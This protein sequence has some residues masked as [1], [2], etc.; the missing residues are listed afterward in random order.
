MRT[1]TLPLWL[2]LASAATAQVEVYER[3][4][5]S[6]GDG[7]GSAVATIDDLDGDGVRDLL[8]GA[9]RADLGALNGGTVHIY[10]GASGAK[11]GE[12]YGTFGS[13]LFGTSVA[14]VPDLD[15]DGTADWIAG[16]PF[17]TVVSA[18]VGRA[19]VRSG[20]DGSTLLGF[21]GT[22][23][24]GLLGLAVACPGDLTGDGVPEVIVSAPYEDANGTDSGHVYV[25]SGVDGALLRSHTGDN[26]GDLFGQVLLDLGDVSGDGVGDYAIA[27]E[28][29]ANSLGQLRAFGGANGAV[30]Y[31]NLGSSATDGFASAAARVDD[32]DGDGAAD[33]LVGAPTDATN[34]FEAGAVFVLSGTSGAQI[35][36]IHGGLSDELG[37]SVGDAGDWDGDGTG[38]LAVAARGPSPFGEV[39]VYSGVDSSLLVLITG[40]EDHQDFGAGLVGT[41]DIDGDGHCELAITDPLSDSGGNDAGSLLVYSHHSLVGT[42]YCLADGLGGLCPCANFSFDGGG[43]ANSSGSGALL[44]ASGS[45]SVSVDDLALTVTAA[46]P[47]QAALLF[48]GTLQENGGLG[49]S[50]GDGLLCAG[51]A[52]QRLHVEIPGAGGGATWGPGLAT[53]A[54]WAAGQTRYLQVWY[55]DTSGGPCSGGYNLSQGLELELLP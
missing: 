41:F 6:P 8:V 51:G 52:I 16:A 13:G 7:L 5:L 14:A 9:P 44:S 39:R 12:P 50:L 28:R 42:P 24:F 20:A 11:L 21:T 54:G 33:I 48:F 18:K 23:A 46:I 47:G 36:A 3:D 15:G 19:E 27:T 53:A 40:D 37:W 10:S 43:C 22:E 55:R 4:G 34:G 2:F 49:S 30:L 31:T 17:A 1:A 29:G 32:L 38:D 26:G 45:P 35:R 25:Y